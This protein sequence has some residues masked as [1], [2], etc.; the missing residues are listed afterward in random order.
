MPPTIIK[1][2][3]DH[4]PLSTNT[5]ITTTTGLDPYQRLPG[6]TD[7]P[8]DVVPGSQMPPV[9]HHQQ[10]LTPLRVNSPPSSKPSEQQNDL[11]H[12]HP[13]DI[14]TS[15][16]HHLVETKQRTAKLCQTTSPD[17]ERVEL[18]NTPIS[19]ST[20]LTPEQEHQAAQNAARTAFQLFKHSLTK[21]KAETQTGK[22][23]SPSKA[24]KE[25]SDETKGAGLRVSPAGRGRGDIGGR[26]WNK[27]ETRRE[28]G[29]NPARKTPGAGAVVPVK[30][31][32]ALVVWHPPPLVKPKVAVTGLEG[33]GKDK[34]AVVFSQTP[35][36]TK[37]PTKS[38]MKKKP[39]VKRLSVSQVVTGFLHNSWLFVEPAFNAESAARK[40]FERQEV[41]APDWVLFAA[42]AGFVLGGF[43]VLVLGV[44]VLGVLGGIARVVGGVVRFLFGV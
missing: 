44:R 20:S 38:A 35:S 12:A 34:K 23:P 41:T 15:S 43:V 11:P 39:P 27:D 42:A 6:Q 32:D 8:E 31:H 5:F 2:E 1:T 3:P 17:G 9:L 19:I 26:S 30:K 22:Q 40:R 33:N 4:L 36:P 24:R 28:P 25:K 7:G 29:G 10:S 13:A 18:K 37:S 14:V 21:R 16:E